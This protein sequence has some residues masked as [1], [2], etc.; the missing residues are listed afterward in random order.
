MMRKFF[1]SI[2]FALMFISCEHRELLDPDYRHYVRIYVDEEIKNVT[3]GFFSDNRQRPEYDRPRVMRV[4]LADPV[5]NQIVAER[6]LQTSGTD[7]RGY[8]ID[9]YIAA[10]DG[11][12]NMMVY[13]FGTVYTSIRSENSYIDARATTSPVSEKYYPYFPTFQ[14]EF[15]KNAIRY[16]PDHL[17]LLN[18]ENISVKKTAGIDTL[19]NAEGDFFTISSAVKSYYLQVKIKGIE[20]ITSAVSLLSGMAGTISL[21]NA[22]MN[23][24]DPVSV[25]FDLD[26]ADLVRRDGDQKN[27]ATLYATFNTFGKLPEEKNFYTLNFEFS[28][29]DGTS[30]VESFDI[31]SMFDEPLVKNQQWILL[32]KEIEIT[33]SFGGS[34]SGGMTPGVDE[35]EDIWTNIQL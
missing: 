29:S 24:N 32:E 25:F 16:C 17:F 19:R 15:D 7:E 30:Q 8:Y 13:N 18:E 34:G 26:Y 10:T 31:T 1:L 2:L 4:V 20:Y 9:G 33:P 3:C 5:T 12:Y 35:W 23:A 28:R 14:E 27:S 11:T 21:H 6:Y 22:E